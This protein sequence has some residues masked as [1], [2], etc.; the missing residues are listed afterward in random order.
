MDESTL[1]GSV[2]V[3]LALGGVGIMAVDEEFT[4][5]LTTGG[6]AEPVVWYGVSVAVAAAVATVIIVPSLVLGE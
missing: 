3:L 4:H 6:F 1:W 5:A 2:G